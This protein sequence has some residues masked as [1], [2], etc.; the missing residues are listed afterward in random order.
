MST[1]LIGR[2]LGKYQIV[3]LIGHGGMA[4]VY[5]AYQ[6]D[7]DRYV[8]VKVLTPHPGH[9]AGFVDRF[10]QEARTIARLQHPHILPLYDYGDE[11]GILFLVTPYIDGGSLADK[12]RRG[13]IPP[14]ETL[15]LLEQIASALDQAHRQG[16]IHRDIKPD[17]VLLN[18]EGFALLADFGIAK[19]MEGSGMTTTGGLIGTPAYIA[20][21]QA[22]NAAV[23]GRADIYSL[24]VVVYEMLAG[25]QPYRSETPVQV[26]LKHLTEAPPRLSSVKADLPAALD[27]VLERAL[28]K[29]A[30]DRYQTAGI[31]VDDFHRALKGEPLL[32]NVATTKTRPDLS[33]V[34]LPVNPTVRLSSTNAPSDTQNPLTTTGNTTIITN[35]GPSPWILIGGFALIAALLVLVL[36]VLINQQNQGDNVQATAVI[37]S[38]TET[39][40]AAT[41]VPRTA[42]A[43]ANVSAPD[44]TAR[45][46]TQAILGDTIRIEMEN[47]Q[48]SGAENVYAV[49]MENTS[50]GEL[51]RLPDMTVDAFGDGAIIF[52][53]DESLITH[54]NRLFITRE[55]GDT[56]TPSENVL[57]AGETLPEV[58]NALREILVSSPDGLA[59]AESS[60]GSA[61]GGEPGSEN[62]EEPEAAGSSLLDGALTEAEVAM[63][64]AGLA[65]GSTTIGAAQTHAEHTINI[66]Q[67]T[68]EDFNGNGRGEN[69]GRGVG[70]IF[71]IDAIDERLT[72][73]AAIASPEVQSQIELIRVCV[74]NARG[75]INDVIAAE[76]TFFTAADIAEVSQEMG[77][78][79][80]L[81]AAIIEGIDLNGN[82]TVEPFE[83]ECGLAQIRDFGVSVANISLF[84][85]AE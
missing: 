85:Q 43:A 56:D 83:G 71:F 48:P 54:Y 51:L 27:T 13:A 8:A 59:V 82:G 45:F 40:G 67:G 65:A 69:P 57:Y 31:F 49:W 16:I 20:P 19:L 5:K 34:S 47:L 60:G 29:E 4:T 66:L 70:T 37:A 77:E 14:E 18:R 12:M 36:L 53:S 74:A 28:A 21:E 38:N 3:E 81:A 50:S 33:S 63:R 30:A 84:A 41:T 15:K 46:S 78:S 11:D 52:T 9:Q 17:N 80:M 79:T 1:S 22:Q 75:W 39:G 7:V 26:I 44:G 42:V 72:S 73:A 35:A 32:P 55:Q 24:G 64:H 76:S 25:Q 2:K 58:M 61:G 6:S 23:D 68:T 62:Y 10:R